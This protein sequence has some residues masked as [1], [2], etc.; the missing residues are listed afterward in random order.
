MMDRKERFA[1]VG[2]GLEAAEAQKFDA[3]NRTLIITK[4]G[5]F[6]ISV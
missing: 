3:A 4:Y 1:V 5:G 2:H 6:G